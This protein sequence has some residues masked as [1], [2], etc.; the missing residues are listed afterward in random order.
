MSE[1]FNFTWI[2]LLFEA[3]QSKKQG[4]QDVSGSIYGFF[5]K[6]PILWNLVVLP[7]ALGLL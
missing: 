5:Q 3:G 1:Y 6:F 4:L 7:F 2:M